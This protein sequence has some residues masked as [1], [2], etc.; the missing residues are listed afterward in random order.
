MEKYFYII[1]LLF[2]IFGMVMIDRKLKLA[3]FINKKATLLTVALS[4][5]IFACWDLLGIFNGIFFEGNSRYI[6]GLNLI[7]DFPIEE[8]FFLTL[9]CYITLLLLNGMKKYVHIS[10]S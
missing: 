10:N 6:S 1:A 2:S 4:V 9:F 5:L 8:I 3:Y 7:P